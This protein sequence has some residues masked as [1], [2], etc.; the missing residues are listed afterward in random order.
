MK[1]WLPPVDKNKEPGL[2]L[3]AF[4]HMNTI[5]SLL[6]TIKWYSTETSPIV[7]YKP[8]HSGCGLAYHTRGAV[9]YASA[10]ELHPWFRRHLIFLR[11]KALFCTLLEHCAAL[12]SVCPSR[13]LSVLH[14]TPL[15]GQILDSNLNYDGRFSPTWSSTQY[16]ISLLHNTTSLLEGKGI[17]VNYKGEIFAVAKPRR[18][19]LEALRLRASSSAE[20]IVCFSVVR[21]H[22]GGCE[23]CWWPQPPQTHIW[24]QVTADWNPEVLLA[25]SQFETHSSHPSIL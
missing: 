20:D 14:A 22:E 23:G 19:K 9:I 18:D 7:I 5:S 11:V 3:T 2:W 10:C 4:V 8:Y 16:F 15:S 6:C 13:H 12:Y 25:R 1:V 21:K 17:S 24:V